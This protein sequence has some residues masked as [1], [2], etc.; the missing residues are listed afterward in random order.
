ML[1]KDEMQKELIPKFA[2]EL[3]LEERGIDIKKDFN[4]YGLSSVTAVGLVGELEELL[5]QELSPTLILEHPTIES[6]AQYLTDK[7]NNGI[8]KD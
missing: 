3:G 6:L 4:E 1:T 7:A 8:E 5:R 2:E